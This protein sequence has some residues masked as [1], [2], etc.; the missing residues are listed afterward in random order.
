MKKTKL[1][2]KVEYGKIEKRSQEIFV[3]Q[4]SEKLEKTLIGVLIM[5]SS[6]RE[7]YFTKIAD[8]VL[9]TIP[10]LVSY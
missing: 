8:L 4:C 2:K 3:F 6:Y 5:Q 7:L 10:N 1:R 9:K